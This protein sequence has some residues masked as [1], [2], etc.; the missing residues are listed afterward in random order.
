M[1][2]TTYSKKIPGERGNFQLRVRFDQT[3]G[4]I[5]ITQF[6]D[7]GVSDRVLLSRKQVDELLKFISKS[8]KARGAR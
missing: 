4:F 3:D 7:D 8:L 2:P 5:G 6:D 1:M